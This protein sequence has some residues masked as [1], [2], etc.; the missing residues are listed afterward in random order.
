M[1]LLKFKNQ[2]PYSKCETENFVCIIYVLS[3]TLEY[4]L[5]IQTC[6]Y[7]ARHVSP[8]IQPWS[9]AL[10]SKLH[11]DSILHTVAKSRNSED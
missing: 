6:N 10:V 4:I 5:K 11:Y 3:F 2:G 1:C 9:V 7:L 8:D